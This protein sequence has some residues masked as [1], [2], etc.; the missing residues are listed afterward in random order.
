MFGYFWT[1]KADDE[2]RTPLHMTCE[3]GHTDAVR[4]CIDRG[5]DV[6]QENER[7]YAPLFYACEN[8][9]EDAVRLC[10]RR[11]RRQPGW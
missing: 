7:G 11:R 1:D 6:D 4:L 5:G 8:G 9:H 10:G 2:G 3:R